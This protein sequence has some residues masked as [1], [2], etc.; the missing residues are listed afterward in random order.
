MTTTMNRMRQTNNMG[1]L[2]KHMFYAHPSPPPP[3]PSPPPNLRAP[4]PPAPA[5]AQAATTNSFSPTGHTDQLFWCLYIA[6]NGIHEYNVYHAMMKDYRK[7]FEMEMKAQIIDEI[8]K[9]THTLLS[10]KA[11]KEYKF[12]KTRIQEILSSMMLVESKT[13]LYTC[14]AICKVFD[15]GI[16]LIDSSKNTYIPINLFDHQSTTTSTTTTTTTTS[17]SSG[18]RSDELNKVFCVYKNNHH[19]GHY[20]IDLELTTPRKVNDIRD[21]KL[22]VLLG[23]KPLLSISRYKK[24][25]LQEMARQL[26]AGACTCEKKNEIYDWL[27]VHMNWE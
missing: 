9:K 11:A 8:S 2:K 19:R 18:R 17:S 7:K 14:L 26:R 24:N 4:P 16:Y 13:C 5:R 21:N 22:E 15:I 6:K 1:F 27:W 12:T 3:P 23:P 20:S 25:E 10:R